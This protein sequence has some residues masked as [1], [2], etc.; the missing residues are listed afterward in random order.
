VA[1]LKDAGWRRIGMSEVIG[2]VPALA[3][4]TWAVNEMMA[5]ANHAVQWYS[6]PRM[7]QVLALV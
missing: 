1:A 2:G 5:C 3:P 7:S 4:M 6:T